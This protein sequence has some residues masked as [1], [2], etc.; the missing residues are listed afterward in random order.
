MTKKD[1]S[2]N[3]FEK[4]VNENALFVVLNVQTWITGCRCYDMDGSSRCDH[5]LRCVRVTC[6]EILLDG[7]QVAVSWGESYGSARCR[8][9]GRLNVGIK[10]SD[11]WFLVWQDDFLVVSTNRV[12]GDNSLIY[13]SINE[14]YWYDIF[15][16]R[17]QKINSCWFKT[18]SYCRGLWLVATEDDKCVRT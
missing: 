7:V 14:L 11:L 6:V 15:L 5:N 4:M 10:P 2:A 9:V 8:Q 13:R 3:V 16:G 12:Y 1:N 17:I 18:I